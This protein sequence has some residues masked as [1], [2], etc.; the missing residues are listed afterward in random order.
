M[1]HALLLEGELSIY[2]A[3]ELKPLMLAALD[4]RVAGFDLSEVTEI[5]TAGVQ[6]LLLARREAAAR[7]LAL[8]LASASPAVRSAFALLELDSHLAAA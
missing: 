7:G 1:S 2:R 5:D 6:L 3:A 8:R 4:D